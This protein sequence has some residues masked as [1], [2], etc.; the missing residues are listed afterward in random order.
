MC[1]IFL[2]FRQKYSLTLISGQCLWI[3]KI[4]SKLIIIGPQSNFYLLASTVHMPL[5]NKNVILQTWLFSEV[6]FS[7]PRATDSGPLYTR[8][9]NQDSGMR[10]N[11]D[12]FAFGNFSCCHKKF[13][14]VYS[15][16]CYLYGH[17]CF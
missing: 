16:L 8:N 6:L 17:T 9:R 4:T 3:E 5:E 2:N 7:L 11:K 13:S 14:R 12:N 10:V 15:Y 1:H